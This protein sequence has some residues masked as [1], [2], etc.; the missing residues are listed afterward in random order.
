MASRNVQS[1]KS[2]YQSIFN[3]SC[4]TYT[5]YTFVYHKIQPLHKEN[6]TCAHLISIAN[7]LTSSSTVAPVGFT[8]ISHRCSEL[9]VQKVTSRPCFTHSLHYVNTYII[10]VVFNNVLSVQKV[11]SRPCFT[12]SLHYVN[13]YIITVVFNNVLAVKCVAPYIEATE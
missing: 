11:T 3:K 10:T 4:E 13:T 5:Q 8:L 6:D 1:D 7:D 12:H 2:V 9:S